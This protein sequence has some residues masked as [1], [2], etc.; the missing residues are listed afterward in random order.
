MPQRKKDEKA[1]RVHLID[2][3]ILLRFLI[4]DDPPKATRAKA[5]MKRVENAEELVEI[6]PEVLT[7]TVWTLKSFY[8]V[9][10]P[11]IAQRLTEILSFSGDRSDSREALLK[12]LQ[13][14][15]TSNA[16]FVDCLLAARSDEQ[17]KIVYTFDESDFKKLPGSWEKP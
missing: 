1:A 11:E 9:P 2:T 3:N 12:A 5:L 7:E 17:K 8:R 10:P 14:Y 15:G 6:P 13:T 4:G 16:D